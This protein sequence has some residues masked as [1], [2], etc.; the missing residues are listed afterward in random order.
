[1]A[2]QREEP[3]WS[4]LSSLEAS[5]EKGLAPGYA[6]RGEERYFRERAIAALR[7][8]AESLGYELCA[9]EAQRESEAS[10]FQLKHLIDD[11]SGGGLF[12]A[13]RLVLVRNP[14]ELLKKVDSDDSALT[15][16]I[17]P[18]RNEKPSSRW[19][20]M[21]VMPPARVSCGAERQLSS[22]VLARMSWL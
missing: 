22:G 9:H 16:A 2:K 19:M 3:P 5:L 8:K 13:R 4:E 14:G 12:A 11:L 18:M 15:R 21:P 1:M 7:K 6:L 10:D 20:P 17:G